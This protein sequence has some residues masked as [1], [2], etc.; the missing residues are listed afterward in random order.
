M[1][2]KRCNSLANL[3]ADFDESSRNSSSFFDKNDKTLPTIPSQYLNSYEEKNQKQFKEENGSNKSSNTLSLHIAVYENNTE[4][5][6]FDS[7]LPTHETS[8]KNKRGFVKTWKDI[9]QHFGC[10]ST[11]VCLIKASN[12]IQR[13]HFQTLFEIPRQQKEDEATEP[14]IMQFKAS[15]KFLHPNQQTSSTKSE[16][17]KLKEKANK[18]FQE[19]K[20]NE[21]IKCY[22]EIL[23]LSNLSHENQAVIYSNRSA[24][25]LMLGSKT[26]LEMAKMDAQKAIEF[27]P[28][29]WKGYFRLARVHVVKEEWHKA[30]EMLN[31]ALALNPE[32]KAVRDE[33]SFVR[34]KIFINTNKEYINPMKT[35]EEAINDVCSQF[36]ISKEEYRGFE[37]FAESLSVTN[38]VIKGHQ[39]QE[40][41]N[42]PQDYKKAAECYQKAANQGDPEAMYH[43]GKLYQDG[44]GV[45]RDY[46]EAL[47]WILKAANSKPRGTVVS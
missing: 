31:Q 21:A 45:K 30:E 16:F 5:I 26:F 15:Q 24:S 9:R 25:N 33:I 37:K 7:N 14:E 1:A 12:Q 4:T 10:G 47:K 46:D 13:K 39:Y 44:H 2:T 27:L 43:L 36:G 35:E 17:E 42:V 22:T 8:G 29:W 40:G 34:S 28:T 11:Q 18:L 41:V 32:S 3:S 38:D 19:E 20:F 6:N 23:Q